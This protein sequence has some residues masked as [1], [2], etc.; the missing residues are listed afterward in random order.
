MKLQIQVLV[1]YSMIINVCALNAF[2]AE[3]TTRVT[4]TAKT[5]V[6]PHCAKA[7]PHLTRPKAI[8]IA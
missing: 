6:D 3:T 5:E 7:G 8:R 1:G 4:T 2:T